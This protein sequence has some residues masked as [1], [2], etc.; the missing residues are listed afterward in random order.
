M[1]YRSIRKIPCWVL[2]VSFL[3][4]AHWSAGQSG[5]VADWSL[6]WVELESRDDLTEADRI[7]GQVG[8]LQAAAQEQGWES[9]G[10]WELF[11][12]ALDDL[13]AS[14]SVGVARDGYLSLL[15][16]MGAGLSGSS[17]AFPGEETL[18]EY[19][20]RA[21]GISSSPEEEGQL[22]LYL[23]ESLLRSNPREP[24]TRRRVE[25]LLQQATGLLPDAPPK[26]VAHLRLA[27]LYAT[28]AGE[29]LAGRPADE[30]YLSRAVFHN[31]S[32]LDMEQA[33]EP[34]REATV[35]S[36]KAISA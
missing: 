12:R 2:F 8:L 13:E 36:R 25:A 23:A 14:P 30:T 5:S 11:T 10:L 6:Q 29:P 4:L 18:R 24:E 7:S 34:A 20:Q 35:F 9:P 28:L 33:R 19:Y 21:L 16:S 31:R 17:T 27:A 15:L 3:P 26:D 1:Q 32:V 22:L